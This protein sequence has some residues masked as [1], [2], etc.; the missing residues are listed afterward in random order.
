M[1]YF[2]EYFLLLS[3]RV[4]FM[5]LLWWFLIAKTHPIHLKKLES[6]GLK[7]LF[8]KIND[9][10][11]LRKADWRLPGQLLSGPLGP[12]VCLEVPQTAR[13]AFKKN[14]V[15][16]NSSYRHFTAAQHLDDHGAVQVAEP[17]AWA[18]DATLLNDNL[19]ACTAIEQSGRNPVGPDI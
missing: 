3:L 13:Q 15:R 1:C 5:F 18:I 17:F 12:L 8:Q 2:H 6:S 4:E 11:I 16:L 14:W 9:F 19:P 7:I 10:N